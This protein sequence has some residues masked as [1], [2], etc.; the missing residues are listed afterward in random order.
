MSAEDL[1]CAYEKI[2][3]DNEVEPESIFEPTGW[4]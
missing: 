1:I 3:R 2:V 4:E